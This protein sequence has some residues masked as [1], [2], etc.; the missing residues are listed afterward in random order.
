MDF[1]KNGYIDLSEFIKFFVNKQTA[2]EEADASEDASA[3]AA[4]KN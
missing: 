1:D 4:E 3:A 2:P